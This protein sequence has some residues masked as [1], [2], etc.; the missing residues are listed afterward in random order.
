MSEPRDDY[1]WDKSGA[2]DADVEELERLLGRYRHQP[3]A[4]P[5]PSELGEPPSTGAP[6]SS[7]EPPSA[8]QPPS[9]RRLPAWTVGAL[10]AGLLAV[11]SVS[12]LLGDG[13]VFVSGYKVR[14]IAGR[15]RVLPGEELVASAPATV[16]IGS[17]GEVEVDADSRLRVDRIEEDVHRLYLAHGRVHATIDAEPRVFQIGTPA[18]DTVDLGCEYDLSVDEDGTARI[19]VTTGQVSFELDGREVYVP[20][21][22]SCQSTPEGGPRV[23]LFDNAEPDFRAA[24]EAVERSAQ[25][26]VAEIERAVKMGSREDGLAVWHLYTSE[27]ASPEL[28]RAAYESLTKLFP[29]P[30][31]VT[32]EGVLA[33]DLKMR[34]RWL[35]KMKRHWR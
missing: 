9:F 30:W 22:A 20:A 5:V 11:V 17:L 7:G 14:G 4:A 32:D 29:K 34:A 12:L 26:S 25:P 24:V 27:T 2:P 23:P 28:K 6:P 13:D 16:L 35:E 33:G 10:A 19:S 1:L 3:G 8:G 31:G 18:G 21:G 15:T